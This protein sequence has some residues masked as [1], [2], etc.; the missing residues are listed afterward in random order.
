MSEQWQSVKVLVTGGSQGIGLGIAKVFARAGASVMITGRKSES[1]KRAQTEMR[2]LG[3]DVRTI[4]ADVSDPASCQAMA[5]AVEEQFGGLDVLCSNAGI[6]PE[7]QLGNITRED[8]DNVFGTNI[9][10]LIFSVQACL[11][12]LTRSGRGRVVVTSSITG[13]TVGF[14]GL[15]NYA[16]SKAAQLGFVRS[17][18]LEL[19]PRQITINAIL[20]GTIRTEGLDSLGAENIERMQKCIPLQRLGATSDI[21]HAALYFASEGA[22]FVTGQTLTVDGGQT[23]PEVPLLQ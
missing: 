8:L 3:L 5:D 6:Y 22:A 12:A 11:E 10:G 18:A 19:A 13:P 16:A 1:L 15:S 20:P 9:N 21:G 4:V 23:L 17:S 7:Q 14:P 2:E